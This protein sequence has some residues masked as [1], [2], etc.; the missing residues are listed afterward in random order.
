M[1]DMQDSAFSLLPP[2]VAI[3]IAIWR[4]NALFALLCGVM[5]CY[6]MVVNGNPINGLT[7]TVLVLAVF[8]HR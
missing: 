7:E 8:S 3:V 2:L 1:Q 6:L 5:L 4:R